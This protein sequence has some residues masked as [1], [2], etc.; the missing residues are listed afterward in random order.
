M[1]KREIAIK[2][3]CKCGGTVLDA[4]D[5][6]AI[7]C[8]SCG[9]VVGT[10]AEVRKASREKVLEEITKTTRDASKRIKLK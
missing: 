5:K 4:T 6:S 9:A 10:L 1:T 3:E 7:K 8:N 2:F